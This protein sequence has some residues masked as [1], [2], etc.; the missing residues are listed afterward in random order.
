MKT[1]V[2]MKEHNIMSSVILKYLTKMR[3]SRFTSNPYHD[4]A[5]AWG[6]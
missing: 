2:F 4:P 1:A 6:G 3:N 5:S